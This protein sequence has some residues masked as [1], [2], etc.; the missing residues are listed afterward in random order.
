[1][2]VER[3][4][5]ADPRTTHL[6]CT[7]RGSVVPK[8]EQMKVTTKITK[9][10]MVDN[11]YL[12]EEEGGEVLLGELQELV[13]ED[14]SLKSGYRAIEGYVRLLRLELE[15]QRSYVGESDTVCVLLDPLLNTPELSV[16]ECFMTHKGLHVLYD[17]LQHFRL[18]FEARHV[19]CKLAGILQHLHGRNVLVVERIPCDA[20]RFCMENFSKLLFDL[21]EHEDAEVRTVARR[22]SRLRLSIP[23]WH[24]SHA[25]CWAWGSAAPHT[26]LHAAT[27]Y[28]SGCKIL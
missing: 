28:A 6:S 19:V 1:M 17:M 4:M 23:R 7:S 5:T 10:L 26:K 16:L 14:R 21:S 22:L 20:P 8:P 18:V 3:A 25:K 11:A 24:A 27:S 15:L 2:D 9:L 13:N 12:K